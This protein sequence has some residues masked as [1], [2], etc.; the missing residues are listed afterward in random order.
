M[1][2]YLFAA[3]QMA[4]GLAVLTAGGESLV[5]GAAAL[6]ALARVTPLLIGLTVVAFGTSAP[7]LAVSLQ[8]GFAGRSDVALG[9]VVGSNI[10]N[11]LLVLGLSA[12]VLPLQISRQLVR[13]DV[14]LMVAVSLLMFLMA[15]DGGL[16]QTDG[17][18]LFAG[19]F[20]YVGWSIRQARR[21]PAEV[22]AHEERRLPATRLH[23]LIAVLVQ[24]LL[25]GAGLGLLVLGSRWMVDGA[26]CI[27]QLLGVSE[28]VIGLTIVAV[29]T[30]LPEI[31]T[32][33]VAT[34]RGERDIAV[35]NVVGSNIFNT[36]S[37]AGLTAAV[38]PGGLGVS[39]QVLRTDLPIMVLVAASCLP[40]FVSGSRIDRWEGAGFLGYYALYL[41]YLFLVASG[42]PWRSGFELFVLAGL[43][44][45]TVIVLVGN[46]ARSAR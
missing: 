3:G 44:P 35:G 41:V 36:L 24:L 16:G 28:L 40:V 15:L 19:L 4:I 18:L 46:A 9:N 22:P 2:D 42:S 45:L 43:L 29:G 33:L 37:V 31:V 8:A 6:A 13:F 12:L 21:N 7:E 34:L 10:A 20:V 39:P 1:T 11:I 32:S 30:S 38:V 14:P 5:R 25:I 23:G 27:A 17:C 26:V